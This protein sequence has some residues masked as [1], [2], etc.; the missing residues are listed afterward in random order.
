MLTL[1]ANIL[2]GWLDRHDA[3]HELAVD[4]IDSHEWDEF[5]TATVTLAEVLVRPALHGGYEDHLDAITALDVSLYAIDGDMVRTGS[6]LAARERLRGPD[7]AVLA[8]AMRT[9]TAIATLD[10]RLAAAARRVGFE[11]VDEPAED[12]VPESGPAWWRW[13]PSAG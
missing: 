9:S 6:T 4:I 10:R 12:V 5:A 1:D 3:C 7:A 8:V 2:I 13:L 11:V